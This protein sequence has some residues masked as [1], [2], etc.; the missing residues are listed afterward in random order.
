MHLR[1][2]MGLMKVW[3]NRSARSVEKDT[4]DTVRASSEL[5]ADTDPERRTFRQTAVVMT[6]F[7]HKQIYTLRS[8]RQQIIG[9]GGA[10][11]RAALCRAL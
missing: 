6:I 3:K 1:S 2:S 5:V 11:K 9:G 8:R 4:G 7:M 10:R